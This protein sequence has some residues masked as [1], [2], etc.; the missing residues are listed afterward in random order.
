MEEENISEYI[1]QLQGELKN[2][3][4]QLQKV[5]WG[6]FYFFSTTRPK[7]NCLAIRIR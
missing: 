2:K 4:E 3:D 5:K 6:L 7:L 1:E